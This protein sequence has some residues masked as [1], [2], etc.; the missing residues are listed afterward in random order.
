MKTPVT[1]RDEEL[2]AFKTKINLSEYVASKGFLLDKDKSTSNSVCMVNGPD[3]VIVTRAI[4]GHWIYFRIQRQDG[5]P[6]EGGSIIDF[7]QK[8]ENRNL[9]EIRRSLRP[10]LSFSKRPKTLPT[11]F[12]KNIK[13]L[14]KVDIDLLE[15]Y[16]NLLPFEQTNVIEKYLVA[17]RK[18]PLEI[19]HHPRFKDKIKS[20][21][22]NNAIFP[23]WYYSKVVGWEIKNKN[24]TGFPENSTKAVWFSDRFETDNCLIISE[25]AIDVLSFY[26]LFPGHL[27]SSWSI[28]TAGSWGPMTATMIEHAIKTIPD[29]NI[30]SAF[31]NDDSGRFFHSKIVD[32][33]A[34]IET[35]NELIDECPKLNDWNKELQEASR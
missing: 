1:D 27:K 3:R 5:D 26:A 17:E 7:I 12:I 4:N 9:G 34:K 11:A 14:K 18:I 32:L 29:Q 23:H 31:D 2:E 22:Y 35:D 28:S 16:H 10:W 19:L 6:R 20:D 21:R 8:R 33:L 24:F 30:I 25:S 13:P 15:Q